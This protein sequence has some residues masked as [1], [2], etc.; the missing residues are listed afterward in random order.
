[1][2]SRPSHVQPRGDSDPAPCVSEP[3][4]S[5]IR[6]FPRSLGSCPSRRACPSRRPRKRCR[7]RGRLARGASAGHVAH[8]PRTRRM[9]RRCSG[10]VEHVAHVPGRLD[11]GRAP[12][13]PRVTS[14]AGLGPRRGVARMTLMTQMTSGIPSIEIMVYTWYIP[15]IFFSNV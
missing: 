4:A 14:V 6:W 8:V 11:S 5:R 7:H 1:M 10:D 2:F 15:G 3:T 13:P 12:H 9:R